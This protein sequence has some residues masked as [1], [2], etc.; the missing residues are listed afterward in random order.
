MER[1]VW[2]QRIETL[3]LPPFPLEVCDHRLRFGRETY[4]GKGKSVLKWQ[5]SNSTT[6]LQLNGLPV[7]RPE[8]LRREGITDDL[9]QLSLCFCPVGVGHLSKTFRNP[10]PTVT[11]QR[12]PQ[13]RWGGGIL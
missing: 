6:P 5:Q 1:W 13:E 9:S 8:G 11:Y 10:F 4:A 2:K 12:G 7:G 3:K